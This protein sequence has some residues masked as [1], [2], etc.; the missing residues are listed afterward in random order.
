[1]CGEGLSVCGCGYV[2]E[3]EVVECVHMSVVWIRNKYGI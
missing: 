1:M 2:C 3:V